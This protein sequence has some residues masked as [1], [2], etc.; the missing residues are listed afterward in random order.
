LKK[1]LTSLQNKYLEFS[2]RCVQ[3]LKQVFYS[4]GASS[5]KFDPSSEDLPG[6]FEHI[7]GEIDD[8]DEVIAGHGDFCALVAS[9]GTTFAFLKSGC[10]HGR[11]INRP[12][13]SLSR[14][15]LDNIP[16]LARSIANRFIKLLW[17]K[18]GRSKVG[19]EARSHLRPVT[20]SYLV[21]TSS[22]EIEF[23]L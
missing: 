12:N 19:D 22:F 17:T 21:L 13:F 20:K 1:S 4:V 9:R 23:R 8:L 18:G 5:E 16:N 2:K 6:A 15:D 3:R 11:V 7:E 10:E 14:T